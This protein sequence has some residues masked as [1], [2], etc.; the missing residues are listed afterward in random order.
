MFNFCA[1][2]VTPEIVSFHI[3]DVSVGYESLSEWIDAKSCR[4][5][6]AREEQEKPSDMC[7]S[8]HGHVPNEHDDNG[9]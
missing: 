8:L 4:H 6:F 1:A 7:I 2:T 3:G 9:L 5:D